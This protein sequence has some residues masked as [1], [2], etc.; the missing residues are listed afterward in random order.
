MILLAI[1]GVC[2]FIGRS[3]PEQSMRLIS[4]NFISGVAGFCLY[5]IV[6]RLLALMKVN[7]FLTWGLPVLLAVL[8][9]VGLL[10]WLSR[11]INISRMP[12]IRHARTWK[13]GVGLFVMVCSVLM[14]IILV[15]VA[16]ANTKN[17]LKCHCY[18][19]LRQ[20]CGGRSSRSANSSRSRCSTR[21]LALRMALTVIPRLWAT[22][23]VVSR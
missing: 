3:K 1:G 20:V 21:A 2:L 17:A 11:K 14:A 18:F 7:L 23:D 12:K 19:D 8:L 13:V 9:Y 22:S 5:W 10:T 4:L 6:S 16:A 15:N